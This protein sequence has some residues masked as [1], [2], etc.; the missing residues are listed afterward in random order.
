[1]GCCPWQPADDCALE[2]AFL[3]LDAAS[4]SQLRPWT[5]WKSS[6]SFSEMVVPYAEAGYPGLLSLDAIEEILEVTFERGEEHPHLTA[7]RASRPTR[8]S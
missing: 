6:E 3:F 7:L 8:Q 1:M 4:Q 2:L 5:E